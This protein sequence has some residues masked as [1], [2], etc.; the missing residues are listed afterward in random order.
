MGLKASELVN[1]YAKVR[2]A[3]KMAAQ[4]R[5]KNRTRSVARSI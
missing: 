1:S 3:T 4:V 5:D 2:I